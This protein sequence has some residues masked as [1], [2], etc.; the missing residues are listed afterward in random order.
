MPAG[1]VLVV[2]SGASGAQI[3]D[4]LHRAALAAN[5]L[6]RGEAAVVAQLRVEAGL[7]VA[8]PALGV[9]RY[10]ELMRL[11]KKAEGGRLTFILARALGEAFVAKDVSR[12]SIL[13]FLKSEGAI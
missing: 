8:A 11:D 6:A 10:L 13:E 4:E 9:A 7:P 2:G 1:A 3:A 5:A 12:D